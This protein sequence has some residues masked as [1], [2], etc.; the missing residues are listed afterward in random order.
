MSRKGKDRK[1][2]EC[3]KR[4]VY[5][6]V[7]ENLCNVPPQFANSLR[8]SLSSCEDKLQIFKILPS[9]YADLLKVDKEFG[10]VYEGSTLAN[11]N[12][13]NVTTNIEADANETV[14][15]DFNLPKLE[16]G[17]VYVLSYDETE[18]CESFA[19][20]PELSKE[21]DELTRGQL[22]SVDWKRLRKF[23]LTSSKSF[24]QV[25][26]RRRDFEK[27]AQSIL[28]E[29]FIQTAAIRYDL[30]HENEAAKAYVDATGNNVYLCW[31]VINPNGP[32]WSKVV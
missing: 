2:I 4:K 13:S 8:V 30:E 12:Q 18:T 17:F 15:P 19:V 21:Y 7:R 14:C 26:S 10:Q 28:N 11:Q 3:V 25:V 29:K 27:L 9:S 23:R 31:N 32:Y 16:C 1:P 5:N 22:A 20:T 24:K 6:P